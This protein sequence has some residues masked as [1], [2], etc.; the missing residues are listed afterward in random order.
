M[1][2]ILCAEAQHVEFTAWSRNLGV[3]ING[4]GPAKTPG[5]GLGIVAHRRI[6]V[7]S[8]KLEATPS[9]KLTLL[10]GW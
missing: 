4:V 7:S 5:S 8:L 10:S 6:E 1:A 2:E 9:L 3:K